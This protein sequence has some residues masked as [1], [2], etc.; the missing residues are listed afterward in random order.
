ME[1]EE[2]RDKCRLS[3]Y[4]TE[5][6]FKSQHQRWSVYSKLLSNVSKKLFS[7]D[8]PPFSLDP[9]VDEKPDEYAVGFVET[10]IQNETSLR[11]KSNV[12]IT[13]CSS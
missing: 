4:K 1:A 2:K 8:L 5:V 12:D 11:A 6:D 9:V 10:S 7:F 13:G 3:W